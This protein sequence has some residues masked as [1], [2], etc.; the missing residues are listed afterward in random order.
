MARD[1]LDAS[2]A[3]CKFFSFFLFITVNYC[4][5]GYYVY[6][7]VY[8]HRHST[9]MLQRQQGDQAQGMSYLFILNFIIAN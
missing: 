5:Y 6:Y 8:D 2:R 7:S 9:Q 4:L 1:A 3:P